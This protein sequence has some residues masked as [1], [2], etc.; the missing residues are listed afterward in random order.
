LF[1]THATSA[2]VEASI[3]RWRRELSPQQK[4]LCADI[5]GDFLRQFGY[6]ED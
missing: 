4:R 6:D 2:S 5:Y 3:G 1:A